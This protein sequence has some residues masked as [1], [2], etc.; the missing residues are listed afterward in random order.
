MR[1]ALVCLFTSCMLTAYESHRFTSACALV[2]GGSACNN[3]VD[4]ANPADIGFF[5]NGISILGSWGLPYLD[6]A[7]VM[8]YSGLISFGT[9]WS[10]GGISY[11]AFALP[12]YREDNVHFVHALAITP[13]LSFGY[14]VHRY[15]IAL[16][17]YRAESFSLD[18]GI[19]FRFSKASSIGIAVSRC[20]SFGDLETTP[21]SLKADGRYALTPAFAICASIDISADTLSIRSGAEYVLFDAIALRVGASSAPM[22]AGFGFG[23]HIGQTQFDY[24]MLIHPELGI[25]HVISAAVTFVFPSANTGTDARA[26][27]VL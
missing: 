5:T 3:V 11:D 20:A 12:F 9:P 10:S 7:D 27:K 22:S 21:V 19:S 1:A 16:D 24:A 8:T 13:S 18:T 15:A 25:S 23:I 26:G 17:D 6:T 4:S 2:P 14:A